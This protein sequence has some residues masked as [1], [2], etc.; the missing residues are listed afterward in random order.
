M[1]NQ[2][3][4]LIS[5]A[6]VMVL[7]ACGSEDESTIDLSQ[8]KG[9]DVEPEL[10]GNTIADGYPLYLNYKYTGSM[11]IENYEDSN[12]HSFTFTPVKSG[13]VVMELITSSEEADLH[14]YVDGDEDGLNLLGVGGGNDILVLDAEA[15]VTYSVDVSIYLEELNVEYEYSLVV[16]DANRERL[17]LNE[18]EYWFSASIEQTETCESTNVQDEGVN[19]RSYSLGFVINMV[20]LYFRSGDT[21]YNLTRIS[22]NRFEHQTSDTDSGYNWTSTSESTL[23]IQIEGNTGQVLADIEYQNVEKY[24]EDTTTCNGKETWTGNIML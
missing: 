13:L 20:D 1:K 21:I 12:D 2:I 8:F 14:V 18:N 4:V 10:T 23:Q 9:L 7:T 17:G 19:E 11:M 3:K 5:L 24:S 15:G 6:I 16:A 22:S